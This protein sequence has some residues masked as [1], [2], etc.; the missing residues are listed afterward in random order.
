ME[1]AKGKLCPLLRNQKCMENSCAFWCEFAK[2]CSVP[3]LAG[4]FADSSVC[5]TIF[6]EE[7]KLHESGK[8]CCPECKHIRFSDFYAECIKGYK[9]LVMINDTCE[10][11]ERKGNLYD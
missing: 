2:D 5:N 4:M 1:T 7:I 9:G 6:D 10:H 3:L 11:F 8:G